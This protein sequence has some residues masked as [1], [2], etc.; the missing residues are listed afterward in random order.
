VPVVEV[1]TAETAHAARH[2]AEHPTAGYGIGP[3]D[4][5]HEK[6]SGLR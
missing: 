3:H 1:W 5:A 4:G 2:E 6:D